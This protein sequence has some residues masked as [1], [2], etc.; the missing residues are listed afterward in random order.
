MEENKPTQEKSKLEKYAEE[1]MREYS[2]KID[3]HKVQL[4]LYQHLK[5][6]V[7]SRYDKFKYWIVENYDKGITNA[8]RP[9]EYIWDEKPKAQQNE[10]YERLV[11]IIN[12]GFPGYSEAEERYI[13]ESL[14]DWWD[15]PK[16]VEEKNFLNKLVAYQIRLERR[17]MTEEAWDEVINLLSTIDERKKKVCGIK[18]IVEEEIRNKPFLQKLKFLL[19][20]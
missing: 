14:G 19:T 18:T 2:K 1:R 5:E 8:N 12:K 20:S 13:E 16:K 17:T 6:R 4:D 9:K 15:R 3:Y 7:D 10:I 11:E